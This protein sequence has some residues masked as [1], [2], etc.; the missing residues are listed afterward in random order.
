M[1]WRVHP[2]CEW[3]DILRTI[4]KLAGLPLRAVVLRQ[5]SVTRRSPSSDTMVSRVI[6]PRQLTQTLTG[7]SK[8][9][10]SLIS[11]SPAAVLPRQT[12]QVQR[13]PSGAAASWSIEDPD[14]RFR[15]R[16]GHTV[17]VLR[18]SYPNFFSDLPN[19]EIY[20][21]DSLPLPVEPLLPTSDRARSCS[22]ASPLAQSNS[23][24]LAFRRAVCEVSEHTGSSS[25]RFASHATPPLP[26]PISHTISLCPQRRRSACG[27][28]RG[29][30]YACRS[31]ASAASSACTPPHRSWSTAS[32]CTSS[33]EMRASQHVAR[34]VAR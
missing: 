27:G 19:F 21:H 18:D 33:T 8:R 16:R 25:M 34:A 2:V 9:L 32:A 10:G 13:G 11:S 6:S 15:E 5:S 4:L 1:T 14:A 23:C 7:T 20:T 28:T 30:G 24:T 29:C 22:R 31:P 12:A 17:A 3:V 26:T